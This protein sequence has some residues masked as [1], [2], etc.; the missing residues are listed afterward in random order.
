MGKP[1]TKSFLQALEEQDSVIMVNRLKTSSFLQALVK[2]T[3]NS[4]VQVS[5]LQVV[6]SHSLWLIQDT[7]WL[8]ENDALVKIHKALDKIY[9][10]IFPKPY[11]PS[12]GF[13]A[14]RCG[15]CKNFPDN[16]YCGNCFWKWAR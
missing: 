13:Y 3:Q 6:V 16:D 2:P 11:M 5:R 14:F 15:W 8:L 12:C 10:R 7:V 1:T 9:V 4:H